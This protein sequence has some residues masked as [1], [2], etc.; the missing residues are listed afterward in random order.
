MEAEL[1]LVGP[2]DVALD[3]ESYLEDTFCD[4]VPGQ[5]DSPSREAARASCHDVRVDPRPVDDETDPDR[6]SASDT[7]SVERQLEHRTRP[8]GKLATCHGEHG[9]RTSRPNPAG[10]GKPPS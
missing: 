10:V 1:I 2:R 5:S 6:P 7:D 9:S 8:A 4:C 3:L